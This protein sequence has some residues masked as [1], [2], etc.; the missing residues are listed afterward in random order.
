MS[1]DALFLSHLREEL[2]RTMVGMRIE[3]LRMPDKNRL[4]LSLRDAGRG[5][6]SLLVHIGGSARVCL[7]RQSYDYPAQPPMFCMLLRKHLTGAR[8]SSLSQPEG[9]RLLLISLDAL[10]EFGEPVTKTLAIELISRCANLLLVDGEGRIVDAM[11]RV[12]SSVNPDRPLMP[13]MLY[14]LP[15]LPDRGRFSGLSPLLAREMEFRGL[16][17]APSSVEGLQTRPT[18][19]VRDGA[20]VDFSFLTILQ[21]GPG[22]LCVPYDSYSELLEAFYAEADRRQSLRSRGKSLSKLVHGALSRTEKKLGLRRQELLACANRDA[23]RVRAELITAN[24]WRIGRGA[25]ELECED[26][27]QEGSPTVRIPLDPLKTPQQNAAALFRQYNK[28]KT[29][30]EYLTRLVAEN[31]AELEYLRSVSSEL[32]HADSREDLD[33]IRAELVS[34]GYIR[35]DRAQ[36]GKQRPVRSRPME[37]T[38]PAGDTVL[39]GRSNLQNDELTLRA[40]RRGDW[41]F[42]VQKLHGSHVILCCA[43]REPEPASVL[44]AASLAAKF[45]QAAES[46]RV[47]VDYTLVR[48]VK[49]PAGARPGMVIYT[50]QKTVY[51]SPNGET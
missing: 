50:N 7:T 45:S 14:R 10:D 35:P 21:Y 22:T 40:A 46:G 17:P 29:A 34:G 41:W 15:T 24:I 30:Y 13:G 25:S 32:E 37:F 18:M 3:K 43:D 5:S 11:R 23:L 20:A 31:E 12:D 26:Y 42:H 16:A 36:R 1:L 39:V 19:L 47:A 48:Y 33:A 2:T 6:V 28:K 51:V 8:V 4:V 9:E 44:F 49:K 27:T 38:T